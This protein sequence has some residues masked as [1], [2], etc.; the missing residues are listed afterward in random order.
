MQCG[1]ENPVSKVCTHRLGYWKQASLIA[2]EVDDGGSG[3]LGKRDGCEWNHA[4]M[5]I[6][7]NSNT[8]DGY[9]TGDSS[10]PPGIR[11]ETHEGRATTAT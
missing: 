5:T 3:T 1:A 10:K 4:P 6:I 11:N 9:S 2:T 7:H 8:N